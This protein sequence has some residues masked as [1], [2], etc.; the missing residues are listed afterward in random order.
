[1]KQPELP[2]AFL[3]QVKQTCKHYNNL[4][5]IG[6]FSI[7]SVALRV[8]LAENPDHPI[9]IRGRGQ[10]LQKAISE[11]LKRMYSDDTNTREGKMY[12]CLYASI[13]KR[14]PFKP[15]GEW[16]PVEAAVHASYGIWPSIFYTQCKEGVKQLGYHLII[17]L[18]EKTLLELPP[19]PPRGFVGREQ[20]LVYYRNQIKDQPLTV[21]EG[22]GGIGKTA[23]AAQL[24]CS[25]EQPVCWYSIRPGLGDDIVAMLYAWAAF[26]ARH[27]YPHLWALMKFQ[28]FDIDHHPHL[29]HEELSAL[30]GVLCEGLRKI[31]SLLCIDNVDALPRNDERFWSLLDRLVEE[32]SVRLLLTSR[33]R[34]PLLKLLDYPLLTG[35]APDEVALLLEKHDLHLHYSQV[36]EVTEYTAG[37]PRLLELWISLC[38]TSPDISVVESL[39]ALSTHSAAVKYYLTTEILA[40]LTESEISATQLLALIRRPIDSLILKHPPDTMLLHELDIDADDF[41]HLEEHGLISRFSGEQW[42]LSPIVQEYLVR[43]MSPEQARIFH[44]CLSNI[45]ALQG[46][47][48]ESSYHTAQSGDQEG[49]VL[50]LGKHQH[51]LVNQ[52]RAPAMLSILSVINHNALGDMVRQEWQNLKVRLHLLLGETDAA[53]HEATSAAQT[54]RT[55]I[56]RARTSQQL[57]EVAELRGNVQQA[58]EHYRQALN[59]L[60]QRDVALEIWLR[61]DLAWNLSE[62]S[63]IDLD[64]AEQEA[65]RAAIALEKLF[66]D[67]KLARGDDEQA[68]VHLDRALN[69]A[70]E[71]GYD[72][73]V[74]NII[75]N[76]SVIYRQH[77]MFD[78]AI[79][80][81]H[82]IPHRYADADIGST[83][84]KRLTNLAICYYC[85]GDDEMAIHVQQEVGQLC[86]TIGDNAGYMLAL[87]SVAESYLRR[88]QL[89]LA[90][91]YIDM[92][93]AIE[94]SSVPAGDYAEAQRVYGEVLLAAGE[95][96]D[97]LAA[98]RTAQDLLHFQLADPLIGEPE[99]VAYVC[100]TRARVHTARGEVAEAEQYASYAQQIRSTY[101]I[102]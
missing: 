72:L 64:E 32:S 46:D 85:A 97:A 68:L 83:K 79:Q 35:L 25:I 33:T 62:R 26:L 3:S 4:E 36:E 18:A 75:I 42:M 87:S 76:R 99:T 12:L 86:K 56:E 7:A 74:V 49:A 13:H 70:Q 89:D 44:R 71:A 22:V 78:R 95:L 58:V 80:E 53:E 9:D 63:V 93:V 5:K 88:S 10:A 92:V 40:R 38:C 21:I 15:S 90:R 8:V 51:L 48:L 37:N 96:D 24:A 16:S 101:G 61:R 6:N 77:G 30:V 102:N 43:H 73:Q 14:D 84:A 11:S 98:V 66:G 52:G 2:P 57:G 67:I 55:P 23:L 47:M 1:M 34:P 27:N 65:H 20:L 54:A 28:I 82:S 91:R 19:L 39:Y 100:E 81:L 60:A 45:Y 29:T 69:L 50:M 94:P 17:Y 59:L 41:L 31:H